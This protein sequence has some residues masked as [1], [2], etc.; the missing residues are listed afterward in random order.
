[1]QNLRC[2]QPMNIYHQNAAAFVAQYESVS[3]EQVHQSWLHLLPLASSASFAL[4]VGAGSG[5]DARFLAA[6]G[7]QV[8]A[9]EPAENLLH[10]A[11]ALANTDKIQWFADELPA[12]TQIHALAHDFALILLSAVWMHLTREQREISLLTLTKLLAPEGLLVITLRHGSFSDG[13]V[14]H[15]VSVTE[16]DT[17][18]S[19]YQLELKLVLVS[20]LLT[21]SLGRGDIAWQTVVLKKG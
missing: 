13:R 20:D 3:A 12:L 14:T 1:M 18:I 21:D 6:Q 4:D 11:M 5:R 7:F 2:S 15:P 19:Q 17:L 9:V 8:V 10:S 16:V